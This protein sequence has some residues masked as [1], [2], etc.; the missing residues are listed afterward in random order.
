[1]IPE[2]LHPLMSYSWRSRMVDGEAAGGLPS[3]A[4]SRTSPSGPGRST[5]DVLA[6]HLAQATLPPGPPS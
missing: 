4:P 3:S 6:A 1:M 5:R 2:G